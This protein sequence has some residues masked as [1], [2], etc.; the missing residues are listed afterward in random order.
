MRAAQAKKDLLNSAVAYARLHGYGAKKTISQGKF[1]G[2][3]KSRL[4]HALKNRTKASR[5]DRVASAILTDAEEQR[6]V[7]WVVASA[8]NMNAVNE[9]QSGEITEK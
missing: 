9:R 3:T 1:E 7:E 2:I 6:L 5:G 4:A 8:R